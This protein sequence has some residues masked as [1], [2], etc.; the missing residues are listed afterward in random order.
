MSVIYPAQTHVMKP[1]PDHQVY[2]LRY[3]GTLGRWGL[4][5]GSG[6]L[7]FEVIA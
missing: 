4:A 1:A 7:T 6:L 5:R 2:C 3:C